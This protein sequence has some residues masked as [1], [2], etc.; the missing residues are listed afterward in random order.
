MVTAIRDLK[1]FREP[2]RSFY[3]EVKLLDLTAGQ[4]NIC[5]NGS[6]MLLKCTRNKKKRADCFPCYP[7]ALLKTKILEAS[8]IYGTNIYKAQIRNACM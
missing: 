6:R 8:I 2:Q 4:I 7:H 1:L 5:Q 3:V